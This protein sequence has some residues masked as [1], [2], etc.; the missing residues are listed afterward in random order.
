MWTTTG[1]PASAPPNGM[2]IFRAI[3]ASYQRR[4]RLAV[5]L[6]VH[7]SVGGVTSDRVDA[8]QRACL[9]PVR[10]TDRDDSPLPALSRNRYFPWPFLY[11]SNLPRHLLCL[12]SV[13]EPAGT[14]TLPDK[15]PVCTDHRSTDVIT[16]TPQ[17]SARRNRANAM[18][19]RAVTSTRLW[20]DS[21][22]SII[23]VWSS[24]LGKFGRPILRSSSA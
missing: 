7:D 22:Q 14:H 23:R 1:Q 13:A 18:I 15:G 9:R 19:R 8:V 2:A 5:G 17:A 11:S 10:L 6:I 16:A 3:A 4:P 21:D 24:A 20:R 12:H